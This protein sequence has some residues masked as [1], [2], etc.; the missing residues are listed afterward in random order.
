MI[1]ENRTARRSAAFGAAAAI[2][3]LIFALVSGHLSPF[4]RRPLLDGVHTA[5]PYRW[6]APPPEF[7]K[8]NQK[9]V[10]LHDRVPLGP[11]GNLPR[12]VKT[13]DKQVSVQIPAEAIPPAPGQTAVEVLVKPLDPAAEGPLPKPSIQRGN[14]YHIL[15]RYLPGK[16]NIPSLK[17]PG[18]LT[19][20]Y[21]ASPPDLL[22]A[23]YTM[24]FS[25]D[26]KAWNVLGEGVSD[27]HA[28][29]LIT[30]PFLDTGYFS[31][32]TSKTDA[33]KG[34]K[35]KKSKPF[36]WLATII[37]IAVLGI[38]FGIVRMLQRR[39]RAHLLREQRRAE[40]ARMSR[41][42]KKRKR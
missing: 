21:P 17:N 30:G 8:A 36:P 1:V 25:R 39:K 31:A 24:A 19:M 26:A 3:Y 12:I 22:T 4:A 29:Q 42:T 38:V 7:A 40:L 15:M 14:V 37:V 5:P 13:E 18:T 33:K 6:I 20:L 35:K 2:T 27:S 16:K 28:S 9:P 32:A 10:T 41:S 34:D 23:K 11:K